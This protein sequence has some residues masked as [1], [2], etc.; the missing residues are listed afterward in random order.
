MNYFT[1]VRTKENSEG[2]PV[3]LNALLREGFDPID[4]LRSK[5]TYP[6]SIGATVQ[7]EL[8]SNLVLVCDFNELK[9]HFAP[10]RGGFILSDDFV[11]IFSGLK[12][13][14]HEI[15]PISVVNKKGNRIGDYEYYFLKFKEPINVIDYPNSVYEE[16]KNFSE[17]FPYV[18]SFE[19]LAIIKD[20][21]GFD[22]FSIPD[23]LLGLNLIC[24]SK[25]M[26]EIEG[27]FD[28]VELVPFD[29]SIIPR[30]DEV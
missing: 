1:I 17:D 26:K 16:D 27:Q 11:S 7:N 20:D 24:S 28:N 21:C 19:K 12:L 22:I 6:W 30:I 9:I 18:D 4:P 13:P 2:N 23:A 14:G 10:V 3:F 29:N 5:I 25:G 8:P 15:V